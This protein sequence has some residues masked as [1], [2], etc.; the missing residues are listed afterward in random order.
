MNHKIGL[1]LEGGGMRGAYTAGVLTAFI[2]K[3]IFIPYVIGVSAGANNGANFMSRQRNRGRRVFVDHVGHK[4]YLGLGNLI[5]EG[6]YFGMDFLFNE[7]PNELEPFDYKT[8]YN[9]K[10]VF[11]VCA[12][13]AET[14]EPVYF[15]HKDYDSRFFMEKILRASS[16]L[17]IISRPVTI[18]GHKYFDGGIVDPIPIKKSLQDG[19][20]HN[21]IVLTR[22]Y[23]YRKEPEDMGIILKRVFAV[24]YPKLMS[25][26]EKRHE[27]YN[28]SLD[29]IERLEKKGYAYVLRPKKKLMVDRLE[30]DISKIADLY[31]QGYNEA[32]D[33][34]DE[35]KQWLY[36]TRQFKRGDNSGRNIY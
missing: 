33:R 31:D 36:N 23:G 2:D 18:D 32:M 30:K 19:N 20:S 29:E 4:K 28:S 22:N 5:R 14:A 16:S 7:L 34:I 21:I 17:P 13:N 9:S 27:V 26:I 3:E 8:F 11:K 1:V 10:A 35:L 24:R 15:S 25:A 12:T 6:S